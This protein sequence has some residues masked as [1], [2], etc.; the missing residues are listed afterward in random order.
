MNLIPVESVPIGGRRHN[1]Q[2][3]IEDFLE[4]SND[5]V[6]VEFTEKDYANAKSCYSCLWVAVR[7]SRHSVK[8]FLRR[9]EVFLSK[10][11]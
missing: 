3:L 9:N 11:K 8:V 6:K 1:L 5:V 7:A 10:V 2:Q 4:S